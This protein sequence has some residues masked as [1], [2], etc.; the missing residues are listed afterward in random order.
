MIAHLLNRFRQPSAGR[1]KPHIPENERVYCIGD[2]HGRADLLEQL[3]GQILADAQGFSGKKTIV[4]LGDYID[5][6][7]QSKE[8]IEML[9]DGPLTGFEAVHLMG[10]HEQLLM[11]FIDNPHAAAAWLSFGGKEALNSYG[12]LLAHIPTWGEVPEL[13]AELDRRLPD[14][15][16]AFIQNGADSWRCGS[17][18]F[19]HAGIDPDVPLDKQVLENQLWIREEFLESDKDHGVIVVHGHSIYPEPQLL[20]NR[21][22]IDTGAFNTGVL[23]SLVL[24]DAQQRI[25]QTGV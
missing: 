10:N 1:T 22:G 14:S 5:R 15:H 18:Y 24:E 12:I 17:Y 7:E 16:R 20:S 2:I 11:S 25:L 21:I 9:L 6:G 8:V 19:V 13:A 4:Y 3:H 23:T